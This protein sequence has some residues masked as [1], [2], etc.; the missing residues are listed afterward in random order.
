MNA[1]FTWARINTDICEKSLAESKE[2]LLL[3]HLQNLCLLVL[4]IAILQKE[5][6]ASYLPVV[7]LKN[8]PKCIMQICG[9]IRTKPPSSVIVFF[10]W[11]LLGDKLIYN[12]LI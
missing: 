3:H 5:A 7:K 8:L 11:A 12:Q 1:A 10:L 4:S 6:T 9:K 2:V